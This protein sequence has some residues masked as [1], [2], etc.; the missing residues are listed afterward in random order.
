ME[1]VR[2]KTQLTFN[3]QNEADKREDKATMI[4]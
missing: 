3:M 1:E 2:Y 4:T